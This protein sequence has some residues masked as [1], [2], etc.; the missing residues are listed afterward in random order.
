MCMCVSQ[1]GL[2]ILENKTKSYLPTKSKNTFGPDTCLNCT[3]VAENET[4]QISI[5]VRGH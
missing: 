5:L 4:I 2:I 3:F 1:K